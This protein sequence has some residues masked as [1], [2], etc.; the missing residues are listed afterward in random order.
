MNGTNDFLNPKS[1]LTPG[2]AGAITM[3][4]ANTFWFHFSIPQKWTALIVSL[5]LGLLVFAAKNIPNWQRAIYYLLNSM[6][7]FSMSVG[8]NNIGTLVI[9]Q[10]TPSTEIARINRTGFNF[11]YLGLLP[12]FAQ[13]ASDEYSIETDETAEERILELQQEI[14]KLQMELE[15][16]KRIEQ[17]ASEVQPELEQE[18]QREPEPVPKSQE[19][20]QEQREFFQMWF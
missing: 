16:T 10:D 15:K 4:I 1:M 9:P 3:M 5:L 6:F 17:Q 14:H 8:A 13:E 7:I 18:T 12:V 20:Q 11:E 19:Q 2:C